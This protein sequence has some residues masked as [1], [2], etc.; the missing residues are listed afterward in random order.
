M[1]RVIWTEQALDDLDG[2]L[3]FIARDSHNVYWRLVEFPRLGR[4]VPEFGHEDLREL[5]VQSY[6]IIYLLESE[7]AQIH[8][9]HHEV[10]PMDDA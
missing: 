1:A 7:E 3:A 9:V 6:R 4:I 10:I 8:A 5:I 2:I